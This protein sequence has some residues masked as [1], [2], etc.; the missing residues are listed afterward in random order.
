[1]GVLTAANRMVIFPKLKKIFRAEDQ[2]SIF[3]SGIQATCVLFML[4]E[5]DFL[6]KDNF[7]TFLSSK[8]PSCEFF[9]TISI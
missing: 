1:M 2:I 4:F 6:A 9:F 3:L 8:E 5:R 7:L